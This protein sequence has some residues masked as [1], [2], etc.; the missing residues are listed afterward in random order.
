[1]NC[2]EFHQFRF[3]LLDEDLAEETRAECQ[4]HSLDCPDCARQ[5]RFTVYF[6]TVFRA[7]C[8]RGDAPPALRQRIQVGLRRGRDGD[9]S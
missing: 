5:A 1:M 2:R 7:R 8:C 3:L 9:R 6:L 4:Q